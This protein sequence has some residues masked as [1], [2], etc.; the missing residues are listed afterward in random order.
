[1]TCIDLDR[2]TVEEA[3]ALIRRVSAE[4]HLWMCRNVHELYM[5]HHDPDR[6]AEGIRR[7]LGGN[8]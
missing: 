8:E 3:A 6:D 2:R 7:L 1:V 4:D 5:E